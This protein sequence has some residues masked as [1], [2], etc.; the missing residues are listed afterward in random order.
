MLRTTILATIAAI[1]LPAATALADTSW[2]TSGV[3]FRSGPGKYYDVIGY[4]PKCAKLETYEY[5][6]GWVEISWEGS[7]GWVSGRYLADS[8]AHCGYD[9]GASS[10]Y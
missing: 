7:R 5:Q 6:D 10:D 3:N 8:N 2:T 4:L 1:V 9:D